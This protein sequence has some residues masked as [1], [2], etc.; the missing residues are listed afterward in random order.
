M[1]NLEESIYHTKLMYLEESVTT[2]KLQDK[3]NEEN[4]VVFHLFDDQIIWIVS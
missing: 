4:H 2:F 1:I 3:N